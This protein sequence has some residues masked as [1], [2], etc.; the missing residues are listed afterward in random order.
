MID[1]LKTRRGSV[2]VVISSIVSLDKDSIPS[3]ASLAE[4]WSGSVDRVSLKAA[5]FSRFLLLG[6]IMERAAR[7]KDNI[8]FRIGHLP[9]ILCH[10]FSYIS[11]VSSTARRGAD[12]D[13]ER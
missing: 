7:F 8:G 10:F 12:L 3:F 4:P 9:L 5:L 11:T 13:L 1:I 2:F 6:T